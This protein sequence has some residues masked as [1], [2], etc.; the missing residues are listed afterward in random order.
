MFLTFQLGSYSFILP[1]FLFVV[2]HFKREK[3]WLILKQFE[4]IFI[5]VFPLRYHRLVRLHLQIN[6]KVSF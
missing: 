5:H 2:I 3:P 1:N 6:F 4:G